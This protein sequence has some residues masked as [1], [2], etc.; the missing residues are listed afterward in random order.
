M[1]KNWPQPYEGIAGTRREDD[2]LSLEDAAI[3]RRLMMA[4][5]ADCLWG[6][7][8]V[9]NPAPVVSRMSE[10]IMNPQ[11]GDLVLVTDS[12]YRD[13]DTRIKGFGILLAHRTEWMQTDEELAASIAEMRADETLSKDWGEKYIAALESGEE[14]TADEAWYVQYGPEP[15]DICRWMNCSLIAVPTERRQF[16]KPV[17]TRDGNAVTFTRDDILGG[18]ADSGFALRLPGARP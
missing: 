6:A 7:V 14:R 15:G 11:P 17:G 18:M 2:L 8:L 5:L 9:G 12:R 4:G 1:T 3:P 13:E 10:R 16:D